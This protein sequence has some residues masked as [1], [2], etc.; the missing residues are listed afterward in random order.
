MCHWDKL[1][2]EA[3]SNSHLFTT[4]NTCAQ[5]TQWI[6][7]ILITVSPVWWYFTWWSNRKACFK[8]TAGAP[9]IYTTPLKGFC[10][11]PLK[12][13][14]VSFAGAQLH[15]MWNAAS[16]KWLWIKSMWWQRLHIGVS[17]NQFLGFISTSGVGV[18]GDK[19]NS[20]DWAHE[21]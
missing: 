14:S 7:R 13:Q 4:L 20:F 11:S 16:F 17:G 12:W 18:W 2:C 15:E 5:N 1:C 3:R 19:R 9:S 6:R 21:Y 8:H 10:S